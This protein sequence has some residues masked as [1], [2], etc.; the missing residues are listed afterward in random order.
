MKVS[1]HDNSFDALRNVHID[2]IHVKK[3]IKKIWIEKNDMHVNNNHVK[4]YVEK[5]LVK[6][7]VNHDN[8]KSLDEIFVRGNNDE[9]NMSDIFIKKIVDDL[10][11]RFH[12]AMCNDHDVVCVG[13]PKTNM[14][15]GECSHT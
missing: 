11:S 4:K 5:K 8:L 13:S 2:H 15:K 3:P 14:I 10:F 12:I 7:S 6:K 9:F 1:K